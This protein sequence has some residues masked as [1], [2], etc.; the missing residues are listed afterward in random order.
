M[1]LGLCGEVY[2]QVKSELLR[3]QMVDS[4]GLEECAKGVDVDGKVRTRE[5][6]VYKSG[7]KPG[8][9]TVNWERVACEVL[10]ESKQ[11][12]ILKAKELVQEGT[13]NSA[14]STVIDSSNED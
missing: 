9:H 2:A 1:G 4:P 5:P 3:A 14:M 13:G 8:I 12:K 10:G 6:P 11:S 7:Q